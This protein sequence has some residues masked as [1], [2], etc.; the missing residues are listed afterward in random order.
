[1][2]VALLDV[3]A[4]VMLAALTGFLWK[5]AKQ[6]FDGE[7]VSR[8]V[9]YLGAPCLIFDCLVNAEVEHAALLRMAGLAAASIGSFFLIAWVGLRALGKPTT[10]YLAP[11][12][13]ANTGNVGLPV[14][15]FAFGD[16]GLA[17]GAAYFTVSFATHA[18]LGGAI[19]AGERSLAPLVKSPLVWASVASIAWVSLGIPVPEWLGKTTHL[20][21][22]LAIPLMLVTLGTS[23]YGIQPARLGATALVTFGRMALGVA[24]GVGLAAALDLHHVER[25]VL[26]LE[27][28]MPVGVLNAILA[29]RYDREPKT[30]A[31][32]VLVSTAIAV[33]LLA[34]V[35]SW[36]G[37]PG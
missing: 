22:Q 9:L 12:T 5:A 34:A 7:T 16:A 23:L 20:L 26:I 18:V 15:F 6:P 30:V 4:P 29:E 32:M 10:T 8:L 3:V 13:F 28:A 31:S 1:M 33:P 25:G 36:L 2:L 17:L 19:F 21:G 37:A 11:L 14:C 35:L 24:V 27:C